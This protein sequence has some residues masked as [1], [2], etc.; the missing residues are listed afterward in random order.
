MDEDDLDVGVGE[1]VGGECIEPLTTGATQTRCGVNCSLRTTSNVCTRTSCHCCSK[2]LGADRFISRPHRGYERDRRGGGLPCQ[3]AV[4]GVNLPESQF[5]R[6]PSTR[7]TRE[8]QHR[9]RTQHLRRWR[10]G[11]DGHRRRCARRARKRVVNTCSSFS[12]RP[13]DGTRPHSGSAATSSPACPTSS[14]ISSARVTTVAPPR[15]TRG[16]RQRAGTAQT[17][18][19]SARA[20]AAVLAAPLRAP[21][22]VAPRQPVAGQEPV[23]LRPKARRILGDDQALLTD[24]MEQGGVARG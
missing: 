8:L 21:A 12:A 6:P 16:T 5:P 15:R 22:A 4:D 24:P 1:L 11:R 10:T 14:R 17:P 2:T 9:K 7:Q 3:H 18:R 13:S 19:P 23:P 20:H